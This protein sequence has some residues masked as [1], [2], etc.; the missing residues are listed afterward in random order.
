MEKP[1]SSIK[2][3]GMS[4]WSQVSVNSGKPALRYSKHTLMLVWSSSILLLREWTLLRIMSGSG[5]LLPLRR[6]RCRVPPRRPLFRSF[7]QDAR[8]LNAWTGWINLRAAMLFPCSREITTCLW[9]RW[10]VAHPPSVEKF[11]TSSEAARQSMPIIV[12]VQITPWCSSVPSYTLT[13][14][15]QKKHKNTIDKKKQQIHKNS[16]SNKIKTAAA[17]VAH[18]SKSPAEQLNRYFYNQWRCQP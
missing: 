17:P 12:L 7:L 10:V 4:S 9:R 2:E 11:H 1:S 6:R 16:S 8:I 18:E 3:L 14:S 13:Q 5:G 15:I